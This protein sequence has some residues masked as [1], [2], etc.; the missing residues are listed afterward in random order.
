[1]DGVGAAA[2]LRVAVVSSGAHASRK[3]PLTTNPS[4][5]SETIRGSG[6]MAKIGIEQVTKICA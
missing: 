1:V 3:W 4:L 2:G 6:E 5:A